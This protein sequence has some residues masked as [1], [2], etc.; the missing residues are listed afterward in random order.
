DIA[1]GLER[2]RLDVRGAHLI[3]M[4]RQKPVLAVASNDGIEA[5][6][7][8]ADRRLRQWD[9][10]ECVDEANALAASPDGLQVV[11]AAA[12]LLRW[13]VETGAA[14][15][16]FAPRTSAFSIH[17]VDFSADGSKLLVVEAYFRNLQRRYFGAGTVSFLQIGAFRQTELEEIWDWAN[18]TCRP[19]SI[20][21]GPR[22]CLLHHAA[23][24]IAS[25]CIVQSPSP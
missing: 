19:F 20:M 21:A 7:L 18:W 2:K 8:A 1:T 23:W 15:P 14:L 10:P 22:A 4:A 9:Y 12:E 17:K 11:A 13:N 6:D 16:S 3:A 24:T 5:W 25:N